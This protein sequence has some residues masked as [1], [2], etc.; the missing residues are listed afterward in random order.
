MGFRWKNELKKEIGNHE[1][2]SVKKNCGQGG[3]LYT[4]L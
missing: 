1:Y 4:D 2:L 3:N